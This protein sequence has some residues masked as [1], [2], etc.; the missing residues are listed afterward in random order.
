MPGAGFRLQSVL[1][2]VRPDALVT[3]RETD[4]GYVIRSGA[5]PTLR[6]LSVSPLERYGR[7]LV[8]LVLAGLW[9]APTTL[10]GDRGGLMRALLTVG[11]L[12][13]AIP[14]LALARRRGGYEV[15][16][17]TDRRELRTWIL[18]RR[19]ERKSPTCARFEDI[20]EP[21]LRRIAPED[22]RQVLCLRL[23]DGTGQVPL[24]AGDEATLLA[25]HDRLVRDMIPIHTRMAYQ[26]AGGGRRPASPRRA[27]PLLGPNRVAT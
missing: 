7:I 25:V 13:A 21:L 17:D 12:A 3:V 24:A 5:A 16:V 18:T 2:G 9:L 26:L 15:Q 4:C 10:V 27:F 22:K 6:G 20:G 8:W 14:V 23:R 11:L 19:G 1:L